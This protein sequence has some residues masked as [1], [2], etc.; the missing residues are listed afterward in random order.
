MEKL[1]IEAALN[2]IVMR[3]EH[4]H[5][6][7]TAEEIARD[8]YEC[9]N[10]GASI[11]HFHAR[12]RRT[13]SNQPDNT[14]LYQEAVRRIRDKCDLLW[15]PTY[16]GRKSLDADWR[17]LRDLAADP[18]TRPELF[19]FF[20][21]AANYGHW[22]RKENRFESDDVGYM[23]HGE[24][25]RFLLLCRELGIKPVIG[26][27]E[28]GD[29]RLAAFFGEM[30]WIDA[31]LTCH[32]LLSD[33]IPHGPVPGPAGL[34]M[35][36]SQIP[37]DTPFHWFAHNYG[38]S[39]MRLNVLA[40]AMGG[41]A[42]TGVGDT[43]EMPRAELEIAS[44]ARMVERIVRIAR[45]LGREIATPAEARRILAVGSAPHPAR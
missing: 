21:A 37:S 35:L 41:H 45:D 29:T 30:G 28:P 31:P 14:A 40:I 44:N 9:Y 33:I 7:I 27:K 38:S 8:A 36:L 6:P 13:G 18:L 10:A 17:N 2:E 24:T 3:E 32:F 42:R 16:N 25:Q 4:P 11:V 15:W 26:A 20:P 1:I 34:Q 19:V 5:V 39:H 22:N 23:Q 12:D 43:K